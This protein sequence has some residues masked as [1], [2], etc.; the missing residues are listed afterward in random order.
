MRRRRHRLREPCDLQVEHRALAGCSRAFGCRASWPVGRLPRNRGAT[1]RRCSILSSCRGRRLSFP[2]KSSRPSRSKKLSGLKDNGHGRGSAGAGSMGAGPF[3]PKA[4]WCR[5]GCTVIK[6]TGACAFGRRRGS[7]R[8]V[9]RSPS[10]KCWPAPSPESISASS[11]GDRHPGALMGRRESA[12]RGEAPRFALGGRRSVDDASGR[13]AHD[14]PLHRLAVRDRLAARAGSSTHDPASTD[15]GL[16]E[17]FRL[18][19]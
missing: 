10:R 19:E 11:L 9:T 1:H 16:H 6:R 14:E 15:Q 2:S 18:E 4:R 3:H 8:R 7:T 12:C 17:V 5:P 13:L